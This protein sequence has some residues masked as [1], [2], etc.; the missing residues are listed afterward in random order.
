MPMMLLKNLFP[1]WVSGSALFDKEPLAST[2]WVSGN[3]ASLNRLYFGSH[4]GLKPATLYIKQFLVDGKLS[5]DMMTQVASDLYFKYGIQWTKLYNAITKDYDALSNYTMKEIIERQSSETKSGTE[6]REGT[7]KGTDTRKDDSTTTTSNNGSNTDS[8]SV[9]GFNSA[10]ASPTDE[11]RG[12]STSSGTIGVDGT[13]V[14]T[15][16]LTDTRDITTNE[17]GSE[18]ESVEST[19]QGNVGT[20]PQ[21]LLMAEIEV[22]KINFY[23]QV[24]DDIDSVLAQSVYDLELFKEE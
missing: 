7:N 17:T 6:N 1:N 19:K 20:R 13:N 2:A 9:Y 11:T 21:D 14:Q 12:T 16:D 10:A 22:R 18:N 15:L 24:F 4:S 23:N 8:D 3:S 5:E